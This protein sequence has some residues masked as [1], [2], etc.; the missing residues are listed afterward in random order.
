MRRT[1]SSSGTFRE[2]TRWMRGAV[3]LASLSSASAGATDLGD[4]PP[5]TLVALRPTPTN[6]PERHGVQLAAQVQHQLL[7]VTQ[8]DQHPDRD[9][10]SR[11][12]VET[13][14]V[15]D[16]TPRIAGEELLELLGERRSAGFR[17]VDVGVAQ[18]LP[19]HLH[20]ALTQFVAHCS[21]S[22]R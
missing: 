17:P 5:Q 15:P 10:A 6:T 21:I 18:D 4:R 2:R 9:A 13:R 8:G 14:P 11:P 3:A 7:V 20:A 12:T 22:L 16:L 19:S 1:S